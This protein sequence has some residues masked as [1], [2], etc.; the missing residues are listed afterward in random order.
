MKY[1]F[2]LFLLLFNS[3]YCIICVHPSSQGALSCDCFLLMYDVR[4]LKPLTPIVTCCE[5]MLLRF[6]PS[7]SSRLAVVT[8][9]GRVQLV[10]TM[11]TKEPR[12]TIF[13]VSPSG[14]SLHHVGVNVYELNTL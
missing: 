5:P 13:Q 14:R 12:L 1:I 8:A 4:A 11:Q 2:F 3:D 9:H 6:L 10:D 7:V